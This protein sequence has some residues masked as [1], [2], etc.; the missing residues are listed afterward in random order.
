MRRFERQRLMSKIRNR[1]NRGAAGS[2]LAEFGPALSLLLMLLIPLIDLG[3]VPIR[4]ILAREIIEHSARQLAQSESYGEAK[5][6]LEG[7]GK[8]RDRLMR[9]GGVQPLSLDLQLV[10]SSLTKKE[11]PFVETKPGTIPK[12]W[13]PDGKMCPCNYSLELV[14]KIEV[15]PVFLLQLPSKIPGL[16]APMTFVLSTTERWENHSRNPVTRSYFLNE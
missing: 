9:L 6:E 3:I 1:L 14:T 8:L 2:S 11:K 10:A 12:H 5:K 13:L 15:A 16:S 4:Y 7:D